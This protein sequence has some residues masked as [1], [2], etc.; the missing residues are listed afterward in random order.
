MKKVIA[1]SVYNTDTAK[2]ICAKITNDFNYEKGT[3]VEEIKELYKTKSGKYFFYILNKFDAHIDINNDDLNPKFE[4]K[5]VE[6]EKIIPVSYNSSVDFANEVLIDHP[7]YKESLG[8]FF[9]ELNINDDGNQKVQ[10]KFYLS[11]KAS[12]YLEMLM[13]EQNDTNSSII[14]NL[15]TEEYR[16]LY[17]KGIMQNDPFFEMKE[18]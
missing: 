10:K 2:K 13:M 9:P 14:E 5:D 11:E 7:K 1:G 8:T 15:I 16:K 18:H 17:N 6:E 3:D 12:W 4:L